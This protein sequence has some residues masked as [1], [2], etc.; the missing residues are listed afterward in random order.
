M[1]KDGV[2]S[3]EGEFVR[4]QFHGQGTF[5][6]GSGSTYTVRCSHSLEPTSCVSRWTK[7]TKN[8]HNSL[9]P[10]APS[11]PGVSIT[12]VPSPRRARV[13]AASLKRKSRSQGRRLF[14]KTD[15]MILRLLLPHER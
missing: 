3:Y 9:H 5:T 11:D 13:V 14:S 4:D 6:F 7:K 2:V 10:P 15:V 8:S 12:S 1:F